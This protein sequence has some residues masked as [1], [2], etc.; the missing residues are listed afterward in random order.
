MGGRW[1]PGLLGDGEPATGAACL[2]LVVAGVGS[3]ACQQINHARN[4]IKYKK[5]IQSSPKE[6]T[7]NKAASSSNNNNNK[8]SQTHTLAHTHIHIYCMYKN[9]CQ[10][11]AH[12]EEL[13]AG[14]MRNVT[15][16]QRLLVYTSVRI[17]VCVWMCVCLYVCVC[18]IVSL[19]L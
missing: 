19:F 13:P 12:P 15:A 2:S 8:H 3:H 5:I 10:E 17:C 11:A 6:A 7:Y 1:W 4:A 9:Q 14:R 18:V 16:S